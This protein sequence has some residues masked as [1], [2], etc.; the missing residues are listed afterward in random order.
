MGA[1]NST[2]LSR[3]ARE[4]VACLKTHLYKPHAEQ[5]PPREA[6]HPLRPPLSM[7]AAAEGHRLVV[8]P[9][10]LGQVVI[11]SKLDL[12]SSCSQ[13]RSRGRVEQPPVTRARDSS[14]SREMG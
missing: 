14:S 13:G 1:C 5:R 4:D 12:H 6:P 3:V 8:E 10:G 2:I 7:A 11:S 9:L